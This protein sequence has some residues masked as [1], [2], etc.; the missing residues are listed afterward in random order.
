MVGRHNVFMLA[1]S[2]SRIAIDSIEPEIYRE[3]VR[4]W[5]AQRAGRAFPPKEKID[6]FVSPALAAN[7][8]L[9]EVAAGELIFR[10]VGEKVVTIAGTSLKGKTLR[11]AFGNTDYMRMIERQLH[12]CAGSGV[13]LYSIHDFQLPTCGLPALAHKRKA[14]RIALPYG[15]GDQVTRLLCYQLFSEEIEPP[16]R[17]GIDFAG[18]L[19]KTVFKIEV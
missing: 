4:A 7:L 13:P 11:E 19:P 5:S 16:F 6:P 18:L 8:I 1:P 2:F 15:E 3:I 14:W 10:V 9:Y 12:E 17:E